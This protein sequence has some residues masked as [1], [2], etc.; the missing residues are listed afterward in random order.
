MPHKPGKGISF[1]GQ[2]HPWNYEPPFIDT[3][4]HEVTVTLTAA[5]KKAIDAMVEHDQGVGRPLTPEMVILDAIRSYVP[6]LANPR[7][8]YA[9]VG[10]ANP[11]IDP[12]G[13]AV[14]THAWRKNW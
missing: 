4:L 9:G 1:G 11:A 12:Y 13:E 2:R 7:T 5:Q 10:G 6:G 8:S 14:E 3:T